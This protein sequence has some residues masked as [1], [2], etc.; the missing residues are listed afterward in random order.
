MS[1]ETLPA[2]MQKNPDLEQLEMALVQ[3]GFALE[4]QEIQAEAERTRQEEKCGMLLKRIER[5]EAQLRAVLAAD[6][7][8]HPMGAQ[9]KE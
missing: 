7:L 1:E 3:L 2:I 9:E 6:N 8:P 4:Q 5:L